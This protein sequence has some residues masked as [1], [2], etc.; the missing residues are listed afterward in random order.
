[1][2]AAYLSRIFLKTLGG[3]IIDGKACL[4]FLKDNSI[5]IE[6]SGS[7]TSSELMTLVMIRWEL[8]D[9]T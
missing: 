4:Y 3:E 5:V 7:I 8:K 2:A 1:M 9:V 6:A